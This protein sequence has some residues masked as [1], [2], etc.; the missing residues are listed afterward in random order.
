M[1]WEIPSLDDFRPFDCR[2]YALTPVHG[3]AQKRRSEQVMYMRKEFGKI[4][5]A[6]FYHPPT[7]S[8]GTSNIVKRHP[9]SL[10]DP[11]LSKYDVTARLQGVGRLEDYQ[12]FVGSIQ[13]DGEDSLL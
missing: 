12:F 9:A 4:G 13:F 10:Y 7:N 11:N 1:H 8:F 6:R 5:I 3:K 2:G